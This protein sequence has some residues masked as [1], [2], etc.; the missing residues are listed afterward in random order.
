M[1]I[2]LGPVYCVL[3]QLGSSCVLRPHMQLG[4]NILLACM[5]SFE[6]N[7]AFVH[8]GSTLQERHRE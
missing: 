8:E 1:A 6:R 7:E 4:S 3:R 5:E 2:I